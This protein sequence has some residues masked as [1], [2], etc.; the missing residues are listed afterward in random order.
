MPTLEPQLF[1]EHLYT[2]SGS[3][4][5]G[6]LHTSSYLTE[7]CQPGIS[8]H[9]CSNFRCLCVL[10]IP[11]PSPRLMSLQLP[12]KDIPLHAT[13][14][15]KTMSKFP[16]QMI[17]P[18]LDTS[19]VAVVR[20]YD[21]CNLQKKVLDLGLMVGSRRLEEPMTIMLG[22]RGWGDMALEREVKDHILTQQPGGRDN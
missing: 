14:G 21:Q 15:Q 16:L 18:C 17:C 11:Q 10:Y 20:R 22:S 1:S 5:P 4:S 7:N 9:R 8:P 6:I 3:R 19:S 2:H 13:Q 12:L